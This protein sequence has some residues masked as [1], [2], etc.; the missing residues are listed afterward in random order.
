ML[1]TKKFV[2]ARTIN[3]AKR[4]GA[5]RGVSVINN[6]KQVLLR[7][8]NN[9]HREIAKIPKNILLKV[10]NYGGTLDMIS[11]NGV[12]DH[13]D[14]IYLKGVIP[15]GWPKGS[16]W[17][18]AAGIGGVRQTVLV[19]NKVKECNSNFVLHEHAHTIEYCMAPV[20]SLSGKNSWKV[21]IWNKN[22]GRKLIP[23]N[24]EAAY[25]EEYWA[26]SFASY[27]NSSTTRSLLPQNVIDY[28][29]DF[30]E[31]H[32]KGGKDEEQ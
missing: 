26:E 3:E 11:G 29:D 19:A 24:Y 5:A 22:K 21:D 32:N 8:I 9:V 2:K 28:F 14:Y 1:E 31:T 13:P 30:V 18:N 10:K 16:T 27:F 25:P 15:R 4:W 12:T 23:S 17:D 7:D 6:G 20:R